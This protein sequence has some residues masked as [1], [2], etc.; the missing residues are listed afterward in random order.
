MDK[1]KNLFT[2]WEYKREIEEYL[3]KLD[4]EVPATEST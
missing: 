4:I 2:A 3:G 1:L